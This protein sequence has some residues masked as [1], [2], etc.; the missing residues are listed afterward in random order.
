MAL[1]S[2]YLGIQSRRK[3]LILLC[4][5]ETKYIKTEKLW[6]VSTNLQ[7]TTTYKCYRLTINCELLLKINCFNINP[8]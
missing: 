7:A 5:Q 2:N 3:H 1:L 4:P 8:L 6:R